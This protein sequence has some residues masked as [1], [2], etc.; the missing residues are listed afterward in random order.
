MCARIE[1]AVDIKIGRELAARRR[2]AADGVS[3]A[4]ACSRIWPLAEGQ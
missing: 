1:F 2:H 4:S 3:F